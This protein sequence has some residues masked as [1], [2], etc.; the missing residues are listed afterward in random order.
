MYTGFVNKWRTNIR[1]Q[2]TLA[3]YPANTHHDGT[4]RTVS[5]DVLAKGRGRVIAR[6]RNGYYAPNAS[7][8]NA[9]GN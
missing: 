9:A 6:A 4:F 5:V 2:Y 3:Y 1:N 7:T 8:S